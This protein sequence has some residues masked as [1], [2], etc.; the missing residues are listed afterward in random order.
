M[1]NLIHFAELHTPDPKKARAFYE[2][3][4]RWKFKDAGIPG[5]DYTLVDMGGAP[6]E[7]GGGMMASMPGEP[8]HWLPYVDVDDV[9]KSAKKAAGLGGKVLMDKTEVPGM[10]W[11]A[12]IQD[13]TGATI[14]LWQFLQPPA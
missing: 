3:L 1:K 8:P 12:V 11:F 9:A 4:F 13:P 10:G 6:G 7:G 2:K 5:M 14:A